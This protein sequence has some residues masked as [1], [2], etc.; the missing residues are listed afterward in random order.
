MKYNYVDSHKQYKDFMLFVRNFCLPFEKKIKF[1][2]LI[3]V[4]VLR[5]YILFYQQLYVGIWNLILPTFIVVI[6]K[7]I[8]KMP[9][10]CLI[11]LY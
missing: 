1:D 2:F 6:C 10:K 4:L 5:I 7:S 11:I 9:F 8:N 3:L